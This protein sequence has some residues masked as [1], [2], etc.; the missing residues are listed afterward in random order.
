[1]RVYVTM[2]H[3]NWETDNLLEVFVK[4]QDAKQY[5]SGYEPDDE[6]YIHI[7]DSIYHRLSISPRTLRTAWHA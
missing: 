2:G 4:E 5:V 7:G 3:L 6:G 1:M